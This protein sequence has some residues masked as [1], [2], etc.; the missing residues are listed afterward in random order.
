MARVKRPTARDIK[1]AVGERLLWAREIVCESGAQC[2]RLLDVPVNTYYSWEKGKKYP[3]PFYVV[4]FCDLFGVT[5]D[6]IYR[7]RLKGVVAP[8]QL[9]LAAEHPELVDLD[10][11]MAILATVAAPVS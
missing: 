2:A 8:V 7:G 9:R 11:D 6:W 4:R 1:T 10:P 3:D 5:A